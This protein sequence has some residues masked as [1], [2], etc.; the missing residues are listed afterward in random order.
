MMVMK[1]FTTPIVV[2]VCFLASASSFSQAQSPKFSATHKD[3]AYDDVHAAQKVDVYLAESN[4]PTAAMVYIH[5]GGWRAGSKDHIPARLANAV[6]QGWLS[7]VSV[8]YRFTDV[9]PHPAQVHD[10][11]RAIQFV[12]HNATKWN[13]D[14][15]RIGVTGGSAGGCRSGMVNGTGLIIN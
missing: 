10:C 9:A 11:V 2:A 12:R 3:V 14:P 7:V 15:K 6:H 1:R 13:I 8:E 5:G 4:K